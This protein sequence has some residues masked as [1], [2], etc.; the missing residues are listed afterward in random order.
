M[1]QCK[2]HITQIIYMIHM[3]EHDHPHLLHYYLHLWWVLPVKGMG[4]TLCFRNFPAFYCFAVCW[5][6]QLSAISNLSWTIIY[7]FLSANT[8]CV[9]YGLRCTHITWSF[10]FAGIW[11]FCQQNKLINIYIAVTTW[12]IIYMTWNWD[13]CVS[14]FVCSK[15]CGQ[16]TDIFIDIF[17]R[18]FS[19]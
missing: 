5:M 12:P 18:P 16:N 3:N 11:N 2:L 7:F 14:S 8:I 10:I 19:K 17:S 6:S 1:Q 4:A 9:F 15:P 13:D